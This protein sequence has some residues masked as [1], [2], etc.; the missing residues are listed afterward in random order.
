MLLTI[1][2][3]ADH[4]RV[5]VRAI[6]HYHQRG[7]LPEPARD[8]S[9]YRRYDAQAVVDLIRIKA[10]AE[11][12]VPLSE[13]RPLLEADETDFAAAVGRIDG[14]L[15]ARIETLGQ[16]RRQLA[17]LLGGDR[18]VL[19]PEVVTLLDELRA[20]GV[21]DWNVR[22]ERDGWILLAA[23]TPNLA[24]EWARQK[25][26]ALGDSEFR[27]LYLACDEAHGWPADDP[28]LE[29]LA[30]WMAEVAAKRAAAGAGS[31]A[32]PDGPAISVVEH[33]MT[34]LVARTSPS[35]RRLADLSAKRDHPG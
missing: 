16:R 30:A 32:V 15:A 34:T 28:R 31:T 2:Q 7:L 11:A 29:P 19:P 5:T 4:C 20:I 12:G 3:L 1:G 26:D 21:S 25:L 13:V 23:V 6:R 27:R 17:G 24:V 18:L 14:A 8:A 22:L 10:L 33:L 9:G 35:W